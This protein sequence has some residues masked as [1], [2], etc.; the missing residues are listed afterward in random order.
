MTATTRQVELDG[1]RLIGL[2]RVP[3]C[4]SCPRYA[5]LVGRYMDRER[6]SKP[7]IDPPAT[8]PYAFCSPLA[9]RYDTSAS[10]LT[11]FTEQRQAV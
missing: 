5:E 10:V 2:G 7:L 1:L 4:T 9:Q 11:R 8:C 3:R 6:R